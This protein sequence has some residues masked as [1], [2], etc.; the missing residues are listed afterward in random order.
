[1]SSAAMRVAPM[2]GEAARA[3]GH[4]EPSC[5]GLLRRE[6]RFYSKREGAHRNEGLA[7]E[8]GGGGAGEV[9]AVLHEARHVARDE[10]EAAERQ[11][12]AQGLDDVVVQTGAGGVDDG[13][14]GAELLF[15]ELREHAARG[16]LGLARDEAGVGDAVERGVLSGEGW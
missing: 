15:R 5:A 9:D 13:D 12:G 8:A 11:A 7:L 14:E 2:L 1:M 10:D 16:V 6:A 4:A 3:H